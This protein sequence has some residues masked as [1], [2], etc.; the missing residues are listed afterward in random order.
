MDEEKTISHKSLFDAIRR[1]VDT[2]EGRRIDIKGTTNY[3]ISGK[4]KPKVEY[5]PT[6]ED[7]I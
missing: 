5:H 7:G 3:K 1:V 4:T 6:S 2:Q